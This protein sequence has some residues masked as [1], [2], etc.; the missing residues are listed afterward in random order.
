MAPATFDSAW[1]LNR[2]N[3]LTGRPPV[4]TITDAQKYARLTVAQ[5]EIIADLVPITPNALNPTAA[6][7][8]LPAM[9]IATGGQIATFG[10]DAN[11]YAIFPMNAKIFQS[12]NDIPTNPLIQG[13]DYMNEGTQIRALNN[14]QLPGTL[15]W[16]GVSQPPD[17]N[18]TD[19]PTLKP[20]PSRE[21]IAI[22][23]AYN[24]GTEGNR[25]PSLAQTMATVYGYP[26][27]QAPGRF[28][29]WALTLKTQYKASG[30]VTWTGRDL[31][32][33]GYGNFQ[34]ST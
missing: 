12:L 1:V 4:D 34:W 25:N 31:A 22:R 18:A 19:Q 33:R 24:F 2:W 27:A 5:N 21:L 32:T 10:T 8:A 3:E 30:R 9:T 15:Y 13:I 17:M 20:E 16:Y 14:G 28:A 7:T 29:F 26:L 6:Y 23:A 11:G